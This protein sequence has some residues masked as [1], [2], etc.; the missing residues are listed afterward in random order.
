MAKIGSNGTARLLDLR[1]LGASL[2][3]PPQPRGAAAPVFVLGAADDAIVDEAR[4]VAKRSGCH[5]R[6]AR[7]HAHPSRRR[8]QTGVR[9]TAAACGAA[10]PPVLLTALGHDVMLDA[11][12]ERAAAAL[13]DWLTTL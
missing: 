7:S 5:T 2:P 12:W 1:A 13:G 4:A 9:E 3:V 10:A 8:A 11:G 6:L